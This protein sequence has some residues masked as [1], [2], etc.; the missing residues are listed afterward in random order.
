MLSG[1]Y[2][3]V[4]YNYIQEYLSGS[5][6]P[7]PVGNIFYSFGLAIITDQYYQSSFPI[8]STGSIVYS[9]KNEWNTYENYIYCKIKAEDFNL[10]YNP[11]LLKS[12]GADGEILDFATGSF[13]PYATGVGLYNDSNELLAVAK[14]GQPLYISSE[15][16]TNIIIRYDT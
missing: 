6:I 11:T 7:I 10:S 15:L 9:F 3:Y 8:P 12:G 5:G 16:N 14:L 13:S 4:D 1:S 2:E